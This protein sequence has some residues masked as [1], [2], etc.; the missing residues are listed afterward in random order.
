M[1]NYFRSVPVSDN[2]VP[3][4]PVFFRN[5][6]VVEYLCFWF[7]Y[8]FMDMNSR[9]GLVKILNLVNMNELNWLIINI[10]HLFCGTVGW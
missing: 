10:S 5:V 3:L 7:R 8:N 1:I 6:G 9:F 4:V 2:F